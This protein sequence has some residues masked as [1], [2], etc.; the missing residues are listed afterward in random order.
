MK[1]SLQNKTI[2]VTKE[3]EG[4]S[5]FNSLLEKEGAEVIN[6]QTIKIVPVKDYSSLDDT[7]RNF[8]DFDYLILSSVNACRYFYNR[9]K[10]LS[11]R[12]DFSKIKVIATGEKTALQCEELDIPVDFIPEKYSAKGVIS[13]L[14]EKEI[15]NK[16]VL[17]PNSVLSRDE[18]KEGLEN[19]GALVSSIQSYDVVQPDQEELDNEIKKIKGCTP[20]VFVF[21]SPSTFDN[22]LKIMDVEGEYFNHKTLCAIGPTTAMAIKQK[23]LNVDIVPKKFTLTQLAYE[24]I[25]NFNDQS[26]AS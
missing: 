7:L 17:I 5:E 18:L 3:M 4:S 14:S 13:L 25:N 9:I 11:I 24:I 15:K 10:A 20:D 8:S 12:L 1:N 22:F 26:T 23:G 16:K 21:T 2:L 6:F 19:L